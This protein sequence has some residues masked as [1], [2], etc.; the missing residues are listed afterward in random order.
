[1]E[2][3]IMFHFLKKSFWVPYEDGSVYPTV[4]IVWKTIPL[5]RKEQG[6]SFSFINDEEVIIN[7]RTYKIYRGYECGSRGSYGIRCTKKWVFL[8]FSVHTS[9]YVFEDIVFVL[10]KKWRFW[11]FSWFLAD[12]FP[13]LSF[14]F[15][16]LLKRYS[17]FCNVLIYM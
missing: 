16:L 15:L 6:Y 7:N 17:D 8:W 4:S 14:F 11:S 13:W 3:V 10:D 9:M 1:M 12:I 5:Y 2:G